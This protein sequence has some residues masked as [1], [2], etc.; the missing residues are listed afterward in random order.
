MNPETPKIAST[1]KKKADER[2]GKK[3]REQEGSESEERG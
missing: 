3:R 1:R 2:E